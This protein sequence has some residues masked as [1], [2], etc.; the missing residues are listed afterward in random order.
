MAPDVRIFPGGYVAAPA[1]I[2]P[3][4]VIGNNALVRGSILG[5]EVR[6]RLR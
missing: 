3:G 1:L 6:R 5:P 2:G 4:C